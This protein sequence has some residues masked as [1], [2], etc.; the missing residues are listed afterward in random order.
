MAPGNTINLGGVLLADDVLV[1]CDDGIDPLVFDPMNCDVLASGS[2]FNGDDAIELACGATVLD[3]I[4]QIGFD[5]GT[6]WAMGGVGTQDE[7]IRRDCAV[8]MGDTNGADAFDP[9]V[10]WISFAQDDF[11]DFGQYMCP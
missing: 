5:P 2:F 7:T 1:V 4:G 3:I 11:S 6:E 8:T 10:E 9:S